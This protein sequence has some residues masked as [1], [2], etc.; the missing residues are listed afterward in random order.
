MIRLKVAGS[1]LDNSFAC[2]QGK[3]VHIYSL[4]TPPDESF[5]HRAVSYSAVYIEH[6]NSRNTETHSSTED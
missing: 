4:K 2:L 5:I 6:T 3:T 1:N